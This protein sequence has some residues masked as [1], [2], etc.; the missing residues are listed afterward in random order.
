MV[1]GVKTKPALKGTIAT[2]G[3]WASLFARAGYRVYPYESGCVARADSTGTTVSSHGTGRFAANDYLMVCTRTAY[4]SSFHYVPDTA[5]VTKV[6]AV[7][8]GDSG[9][10][11]IEPAVNISENDFL[12]N[13]GPDGGGLTPDY[14]GSP[15]QIYADPVGNANATNPYLDTATGGHFH[16]WIE[17]GFMDVD[18]LVTD[19]SG[20]P[21]VAIPNW[22]IGKDEITYLGRVHTFAS[23]D[24]TP[25]V[26][27]GTLFET[28]GSTT[29]T[30]FDDGIEGQKI[31]V[32]AGAGITIEHGA[33]KIELIG[34]TDF[35]MVAGEAI[36][37]VKWDDGTWY[38]INRSDAA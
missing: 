26:A 22:E 11:T 13:L 8:Q 2:S 16:G 9:S 37:F 30:D 29:I 28:A 6:T 35:V 38:E 7:T 4:G 3:P 23:A 25:S 31:T 5:K 19:S 34:D 24:A 33:G 10:M 36:E 20:T 21:V 15:V 18:L 14:D 1:L 32:R 12:L 17:T 27:G